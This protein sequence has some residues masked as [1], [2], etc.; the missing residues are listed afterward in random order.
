MGKVIVL[1][2]LALAGCRAGAESPDSV[3]LFGCTCD[4]A[5]NARAAAEVGT[6]PKQKARR[7]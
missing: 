7:D 3:I 1:L 6:P 4:N 5:A 2:S